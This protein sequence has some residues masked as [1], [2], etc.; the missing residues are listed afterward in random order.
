MAPLILESLVPNILAMLHAVK[1]FN[2]AR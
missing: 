1:E 2:A